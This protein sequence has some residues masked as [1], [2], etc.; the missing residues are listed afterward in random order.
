MRILDLDLDFFLDSIAL[1]QSSSGAR[2]SEDD[3]K[4]W[5]G[6]KVREF[7]E[8]QC[9]L[10][11]R[12]RILGK[13]VT[14]HHEAFYWWRDLIRDGK[15]AKP[16]EVVHVDAHADLGAGTFGYSKCYVGF[17]LMHKPMEERESPEEGGLT[18]NAGNYL[19]VAIACRW[20]NKLVYVM[21]P[22]NR[23]E[24]C[25]E[26]LFLDG[27]DEA[28]AIS[29]PKLQKPKVAIP[30]VPLQVIKREPPV[31]FAPV[32][33]ST[34]HDDGSFD[35]VVL[36]QSPGFTPQSSDLLVPLIK[37]YMDLT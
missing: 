12:R 9:G 33:G 16:F 19:L 26:W 14:H 4:P 36:C 17:D 24:D 7:L 6:D 28:V 21:H 5:S 25:E 35:F 13:Y 34:F 1:D 18:M 27:D 20:L 10:S 32:R 29:L 30:G 37:E 31:E 3:F 15:L 23:L 22:D 8:G 2:L 11:T